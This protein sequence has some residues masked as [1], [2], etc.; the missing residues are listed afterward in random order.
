MKDCLTIDAREYPVAEDRNGNTY[1]YLSFTA[2]MDSL[3]T[4]L[5][6]KGLSLTLPASYWYLQHF[7]ITHLE[8]HV[9]WFNVSSALSSA[10]KLRILTQR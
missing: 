1:D 10:N 3:K 8:K 9:D 5:G 2:W 4:S 7:D 6:N